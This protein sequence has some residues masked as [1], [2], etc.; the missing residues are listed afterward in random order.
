MNQLINRLLDGLSDY[1]AHRKGLLLLVALVLV[2]VNF[3][4]ELLPSI[5]WLSESDFFL[6]LGVILTILGVLLGWAL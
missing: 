3:L 5:G 2:V 6:H 1:L 4:L